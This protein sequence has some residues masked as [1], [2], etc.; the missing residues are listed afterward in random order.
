MLGCIFESIYEDCNKYIYC[1]SC[2]SWLFRDSIVS[3]TNSCLGRNRN[4]V[5]RWRFV[6]IFDLFSGKIE[7]QSK[8]HVCVMKVS[9][10]FKF[11]TRGTFNIVYK[12]GSCLWIF[13]EC[14][15]DFSLQTDVKC[16]KIQVPL[17]CVIFREHFTLV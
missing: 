3:A 8:S 1:E 17:L 9:T 14:F 4:L 10:F 12:F 5:S 2:D 7:K 13:D 16:E 15:I 6:Q 11:L